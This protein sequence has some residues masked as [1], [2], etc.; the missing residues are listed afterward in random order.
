MQA[1]VQTMQVLRDAGA[2]VE[3]IALPLDFNDLMVRN[4]RIIAAEAYALHRSYID[5][6][7]LDI[8]P[9]VRRRVLT[10]KSIGAAEYIDELAQRRRTAAQFAQWM[11][12]RAAVLTPTVPITA[13]PLESVDEATTPLAAFTRGANYLGA[14]ALSLPAGFSREGLP[15]GAQLIGAPFAEA[16]LIAVGRAFQRATDWHRRRPPERAIAAREPA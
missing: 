13:T 8:D 3:E 6:Q 12:G 15:I 11:R 16:S 5:D 7:A 9:W 1:H 4:G 14:C 2:I 10:G